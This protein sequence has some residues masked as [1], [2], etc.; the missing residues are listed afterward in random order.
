MGPFE[1]FSNESLLSIAADVSLTARFREG[2]GW[3]NSCQF[4]VQLEVAL[5]KAIH[6]RCIMMY[7]QK[8]HSY[9]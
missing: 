2:P 5:F 8:N 3:W 7:P 4:W 9:P 1:V 6:Y